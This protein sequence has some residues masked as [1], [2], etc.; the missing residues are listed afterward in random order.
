MTTWRLGSDVQRD[1]DHKGLPAG[2]SLFVCDDS[3]STFW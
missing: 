3:L 2:G 1:D